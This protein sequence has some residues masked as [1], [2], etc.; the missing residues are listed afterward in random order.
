M[1]HSLTPSSNLIRLI[2]IS[3]P[4]EAARGAWE[5]ILA[6][7]RGNNARHDI[8][9]MLL[10]GGTYFLQLLEGERAAVTDTFLRLS[11]DPRHK[12]IELVS[13]AP[14]EVRLFGDWS[15]RP[16]TRVET[17]LPTIL[18][19]QLTTTDVYRMSATRIEQ[20]CLDFSALK[21]AIS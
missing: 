15:M 20:L 18:D 12:R 16:F 19:A 8:T 9:G 1:P 11:K 21:V 17:E 3:K 2:Y 14:A 10:A 6:S 13:S 7:S 4:T 5:S